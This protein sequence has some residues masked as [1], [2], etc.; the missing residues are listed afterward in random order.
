MRGSR[1]ILSSAIVALVAASARAEVVFPGVPGAEIPVL[2]R[3]VHPL[4]AGAVAFGSEPAQTDW[5][6]TSN[7]GRR[8]ADLLIL[9][10]QTV[11]IGDRADDD[12]GVH[13]SVL[14]GDIRR[15][16]AQGEVATHFFAPTRHLWQGSANVSPSPVQ[17][18][19]LPTP[20][21][22]LSSP[23]GGMTSPEM[24]GPASTGMLGSLGLIGLIWN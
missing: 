21:L 24:G 8:G 19:D 3:G 2:P 13:L 17:A 22:D 11:A 18:Y 14:S 4:D 1:V 7:I 9:D 16:R 6:G 10:Y 15:D 20:V 23:G 12:D 5:R